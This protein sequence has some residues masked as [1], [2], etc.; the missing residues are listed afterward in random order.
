MFSTF[1][2]MHTRQSS[3]HFCIVK[4]KN[5]KHICVQKN[6]KVAQ[7]I[8][9]LYCEEVVRPSSLKMCTEQDIQY[10]I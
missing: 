6:I 5:L 8:D 4:I 3:L 2:D 7:L 1:N 9:N 10:C